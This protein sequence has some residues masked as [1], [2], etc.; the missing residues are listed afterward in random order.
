[1]SGI[2]TWIFTV[3]GERADPLANTT[4]QTNVFRSHTNATLIQLIGQG[5][6]HMVN[7]DLLYI[8]VELK[9]INLRSEDTNN[10]W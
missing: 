2:Q 10:N 3:K 5:V 4:V 8:I 6:V 9:T 1:M 7:M